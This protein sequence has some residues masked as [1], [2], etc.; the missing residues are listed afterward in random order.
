[1]KVRQFYLG[2]RAVFV[3]VRHFYL[4]LRAVFLQKGALKKL[5]CTG[6][7]PSA[8]LRMTTNPVILRERSEP[9][10]LPAAHCVNLKP[11]ASI[12]TQSK[13][14]PNSISLASKRV[15][16]FK[17][18]HLARRITWQLI[19]KIES[20]RQFVFRQT[21]TGKLTQLFKL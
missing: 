7:D 21:L 1:M 10:D 17:L 4:R 11:K 2:P 15:L 19:E 20:T 13:L 8:T 3:K 9:K 18:L 5:K 6:G 12:Q 14:N 16:N